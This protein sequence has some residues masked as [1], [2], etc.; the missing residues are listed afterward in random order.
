[1]I[2][3]YQPEI[4]FADIDAMGHV[5]NATYLSYFEQARIQYFKDLLDQ[6]WDW[7]SQGILL[8]RN[9][10]NYK[11]PIL[12]TDDVYIRTRCVNIGSKSL[13]FAYKIEKQL[14]DGS[15]LE[16]S[17]GQSVLVCFDS[18]KQTTIPVPQEWKE[19]IIVE[20]E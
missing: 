12:L 3:T 16:C 7:N 15:F 18:I 17:D 2:S 13:T 19:K 9:E 5:N 20:G 6:K 1:M 4:R 14:K 11:M 8:A 10:V